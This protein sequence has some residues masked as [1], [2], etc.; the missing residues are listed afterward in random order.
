MKKEFSSW[1]KSN[2]GYTNPAAND[3]SSRLRRALSFH[4]ID[5]NLDQASNIF[6]L[7]QTHGFQSLTVSVKSQLRRAVKLHFEFL[8]EKR[9]T[10]D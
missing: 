8:S 4:Q 6:F 3:V 7:E 1:L 10:K 2:K 5:W 9:E